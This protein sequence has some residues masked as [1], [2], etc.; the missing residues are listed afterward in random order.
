MAACQA[1]GVEDPEGSRFCN[2]CGERFA[3]APRRDDQA[4]AAL[5]RALE[6]HARKGA[7]AGGT[8]VARH[9]AALGLG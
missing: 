2:A 1:C 7:T 3:E 5:D 8:V 9:A 4:R 6:L